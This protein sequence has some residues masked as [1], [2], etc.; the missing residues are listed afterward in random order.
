MIKDIIIN[1]S[2]TL[3]FIQSGKMNEIILSYNNESK[4]LIH[5]ELN[6]EFKNLFND[7]A[8]I[9]NDVHDMYKAIQS[10]SNT[11]SNQVQIL[12]NSIFSSF[13]IDNTLPI[14]DKEIK[15]QELLLDNIE[16]KVTEI[17][18]ME[19]KELKEEKKEKL[20][21]QKD[22]YIER[23]KTFEGFLSFIEEQKLFLDNSKVTQDILNAIK[24][25]NKQ[26]E[27]AQSMDLEQL[28]KA[29]ENFKKGEEKIK[30]NEI[31]K[32][33]KKELKDK[34][35]LE[36]NENAKKFEQTIEEGY[37]AIKMGILANIFAN[38]GNI[39]VEL[40][41]LTKHMENMRK[42]QEEMNDYFK[43]YADDEN[44]ELKEQQEELKAD[45]EELNDFFKDYTGNENDENA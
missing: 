19:K 30:E 6:S 8:L 38:E 35:N 12:D 4:S 39:S 41:E 16:K 5:H 45:I 13:V 28:E 40:K 3:S 25:G 34:K 33:E 11:N 15:N 43:N 9:K 37:D 44:E 31:K 7:K 27:A 42:Y 1:K 26:I 32:E 17:Q 10:K 18:E 36:S 23:M 20:L 14:L 29:N 21:N 2:M 24:K 22:K